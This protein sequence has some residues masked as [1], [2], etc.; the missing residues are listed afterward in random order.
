M[1]VESTAIWYSI[2]GLTAFLAWLKL[3]VYMAIVSVAIVLSFHLKSKPSDFGKRAPE[4]VK[5][6]W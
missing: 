3:S 5:N 6:S 2:D 1:S 4:Y